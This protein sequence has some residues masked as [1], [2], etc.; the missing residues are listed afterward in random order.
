[1][2]KVFALVFMFTLIASSASY[3]LPLAEFDVSV[4]VAKPAP[5]GDITYSGAALDLKDTLGLATGSDT[6][7]RLDI[8]HS[9][10]ILPN[11]YLHHLPIKVEGEK[12]LTQTI[13]YGSQT[14]SATT[15]VASIL[16]LGQDDIGLY[17]RVPFVATA[18]HEVV[19][20]KA[21]L[22]IR[23]LSFKASITAAALNK[24]EE[25]SFS[26]PIPMIYAG[27]DINPFEY[28]SLVADLKMLSVGGNSM[29]EYSA[30]LRIK[31]VHFF[32]LGAGYAS[33]SIKID[34]NDVKANINFAEPYFFLGAAF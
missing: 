22:N 26:S 14:F 7:L 29:T 27:L 20:L 32:Y 30:E 13:T 16:E 21:G 10:P 19:E 23:M 15:K 17:Y 11:I 3:A 34:T 18:T 1:M 31:P 25:K 4:G 2:K 28:L 33:E 5:S 6:I 24:T 9:I 12:E 8:K